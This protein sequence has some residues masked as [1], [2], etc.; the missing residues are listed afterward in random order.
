MA[1]WPL[2][3]LFVLV[4]ACAVN[5]VTGRQQ[6]AL[7]STAQEVDLGAHEHP[8]ILAEYG[9]L[10][11]PAVRDYVA[12]VGQGLAARSH[13]PGIAYHFTVLDSPIL[14]AFAIPGGYV[15]VT[16]GLLA[17]LNNEAELAGVIGH[18][19]GHVTARHGV[20]RYTQQ[21]GYQLL[22][23]VAL[24]LEPGLA[25]WTQLSDLAFTATVRGYGRN[26]E[27]QSDELGLAYAAAAGYD[28]GQ[29]HHF[30]E[31]LQR[32]ERDADGGGYHGLFATHPETQARIERLRGLERANPG[33]KEVGREAYLQAIDGITVGPSPDEGRVVEG[34]YLNVP[35]DVALTIPGGWQAR[36][37][38]G[39][40][41]LTPRGGGVAWE[42]QMRPA[43]AG[44]NSETVM[45]QLLAQVGSPARPAWALHPHGAQVV[46]A[47]ASAAGKPVGVRITTWV[48]QGHVT[49]VTALAP[50][51]AFA[52]LAP[53]FDQITATLAPLTA[54]E[55]QRAQPL[56][57]RIQ[58]AQAATSFAALAGSDPTP[59]HDPT[60]LSF[61]NGY[62]GAPNPRAGDLVKVIAP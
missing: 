48:H 51:G 28:T 53:A 18:E 47:A 11:A 21:A 17:E 44:E 29:L 49:V 45:R 60:W 40:L 54:S 41:L 19:I 33:G 32:Q 7:L 6:V 34:R 55:I 58:R 10:Q 3:A 12:R 23:G 27:L 57:L 22:R 43:Q 35:Y 50:A 39:R 42:A 61:F 46:D 36:T 37:A 31:T 8:A 38:R 62:G 4:A 56:H 24:M 5:P 30:F 59:D 13:R 26:E 16:R 14:N 1:R 52:R 20:T 25:N 9:E 15:Y 2:A